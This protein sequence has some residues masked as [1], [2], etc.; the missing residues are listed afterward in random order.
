MPLSQ[1][2]RKL[3]DVGLLTLLALRPLPHPDLIDQGFVHLGQPSVTTNPLPAH[4]SHAVPPPA[5]DVHFMDF[6][7]PDDRIHML[8][9]DDSKLEPIVVDESY[10]VD[11]VISDPQAFTPFRLVPNT[12]PVHLTTDVQYVIRGGRMIRQQPPIVARPLESDVTQE[13]TKREDD[14]ILRALS[15]IQVETSISPEGLIHML[16]VDKDTYIVFSADDLP[17]VDN[18]SAVNICLQATIVALGFGPS[19]FEPSSQIVLRIPTSFNLLLG[20]PWIHGKVKFIYKG[21][22]IT[23]QS[24]G[25]T[26]STSKSILE[27]SHGDDDLLLTGFTFDE[28]LTM[29]T[30]Q[31]CRDHVTLPFDEHVD[32][33]TPFDLGFVPIEADYKYMALLCKE[34][35][36]AHLLYMP[37][38]YLVCPYRMSLADYF[39]LVHLLQ[40][41]D[42]A[43]GTST[44]IL[45]TPLFPNHT[46]LLALYFPKETDEYG[47]SVEIADMIDE[48]ILRDEYSY[49][50][51]MPT[52]TSPLNLFGVLAIEMAEDVQHVPIPRL[53]TI[54]AHDDDVLEGILARLW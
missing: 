7:K 26:Y 23:I 4:T 48:V 18:G 37:F 53:L 47:T 34:R 50:M 12:P 5:G 27:I 32:H 35:L 41:G 30:E 22:V 10:E 44:S 21:R 11:G 36:R 33:D 39:C 3:T 17:H 29:E 46:S 43:P 52:T 24:T 20:W 9:L 38:D 13:E 2:L 54:V 51:L 42:E 8:S 16:T 40:L 25:D 45:V 14:E 19:D 15:Q 49:E 6:T 28:I 31:F 1:A